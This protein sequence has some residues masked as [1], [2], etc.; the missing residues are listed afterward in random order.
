MDLILDLGPV[1][2]LIVPGVRALARG[3]VDEI[4]DPTRWRTLTVSGCAFPQSMAVVDPSSY[5][6][7]DR[8]EWLAWRE[9]LYDDRA[10]VARLPRL[11][12]FS[13]CAIQHPLGVEGFD[14]RIMSA[15]AST[16]VATGDQWLLIKGVSTDS[17]AP[18]IQF[19]GLATQLV[20]GH[21]QRAH[22]KG[23]TH[24]TG[25]AGMKLCAD[26]GPKVGTPEAWRRLG[27]IHHLTCA[28]EQIG[29]LAWR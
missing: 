11:P 25:C 19:P 2:S 18:S 20:Y 8:I 6:L 29:A 9:E 1:E 24:C 12:T 22:W 17:V 14:P 16:R 13:D 3:F 10:D 7:V 15:S 5:A 27:T 23:E 28:A 4:P 21:L 26:G